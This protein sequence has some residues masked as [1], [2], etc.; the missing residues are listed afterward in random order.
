LVFNHS[1]QLS[2]QGANSAFVGYVNGAYSAAR[3]ISAPLFGYWAERRTFK[4]SV[5][6][7]LAIFVVGNM[8]YALAGTSIGSPM[9]ILIARF[10]VGLG[11]GIYISPPPLPL[12]KTL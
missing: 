9:M 8:L 4:E 10:L 7:N 1:I 11:S 5:V 2:Q 6:I 3:L 12:K